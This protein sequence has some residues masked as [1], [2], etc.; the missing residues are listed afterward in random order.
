MEVCKDYEPLANF[1][2]VRIL[3]PGC[4]SDQLFEHCIKQKMMIRDCSTFPFL[5]HEYIRFCFMTPKDNN[6]LLTAM[7]EYLGESFEG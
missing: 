3:K 2:L 6:R 4:S 1:M 7:A 5:N